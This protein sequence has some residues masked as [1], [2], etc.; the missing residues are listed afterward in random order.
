MDTQVRTAWI[1]ASRATTP[2]SKQIKRGLVDKNW[3]VRLGWAECM[4]WTPN[5][6]QAERGLVDMYWQVRTAWAKR[7]DFTPTPE[8]IERGLAD[9]SAEVRHAWIDR[10][11]KLTNTLIDDNIEDFG[12]QS[13]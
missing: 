13:I 7:M 6:D 4:D 2:T 3:E 8:Q 9:V 1:G 12:I 5:P 10:V 11:R